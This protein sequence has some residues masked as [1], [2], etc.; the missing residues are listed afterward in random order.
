MKIFVLVAMCIAYIVLSIL[1][2]R[3]KRSLGLS[4]AKE[5]S[6]AIWVGIFWVNVPILPI[7]LGPLFVQKELLS[8]NEANVSILCLTGGFIGAW[9]WWS[10]NVSLWRRWAYRK[11]VDANE[12]QNEGQSSSILWPRGHFFEKTEF[13]N[14][15]KHWRK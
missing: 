10:V 7:F 14:L 5:T 2:K 9:L 13:G 15:V 1:V 3:K 12:L 6:K 11:G 8:N 4:P